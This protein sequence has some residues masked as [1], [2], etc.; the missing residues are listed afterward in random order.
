MNLNANI[1]LNTIATFGTTTVLGA[2]LIVS[3]CGGGGG[4]GS[5][6]AQT[7][8]STTI[9]NTIPA[10]AVTVSGGTLTV[11]PGQTIIA[12]PADSTIS[13]ISIPAGVI[14]TPPAGQSFTTATTIEVT[15]FNSVSAMPPPV[16]SGFK[17]D[18]VAGAVDIKIGSVNGTTFSAPVTI[19]I[20]LT[21]TVTNCEVFVNK[22][23]GLGY[24]DL[25]PAIN[26][27]TCNADGFAQIA[28]S[29]LC[30]FVVNPHFTND[31]TGSTGISGSGTG[32]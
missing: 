32:F 27:T 1:I 24:V 26:N 28:V 20:P 14:I 22:G 29:D 13:V 7:P 2:I 15:T 19:S 8:T 10:S 5:T 31:T 6:P 25:G 23:N 11:A 4:G 9:T 12:Q 16:T 30:T 18:S 3:G 17:V 21:G